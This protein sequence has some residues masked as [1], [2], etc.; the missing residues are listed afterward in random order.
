MQIQHFVGYAIR[1]LIVIFIE[2][3]NL[4]IFFFFSKEYIFNLHL[5]GLLLP[6]L[7]DWLGDIKTIIY[8]LRP[9]GLCIN[10]P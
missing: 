5:L 9:Q 3:Q 8:T 1:G 7:F 4:G 2:Q 10:S 6:Y